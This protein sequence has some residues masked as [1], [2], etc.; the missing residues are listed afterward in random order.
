MGGA[1]QL[2]MA[3]SPGADFGQT[4]LDTRLLLTGRCCFPKI[5]SQS[6]YSAAFFEFCPTGLPCS[7][8]GDG[9]TPFHCCSL[10]RPHASRQKQFSSRVFRSNAVPPLSPDSHSFTRL[11]LFLRPADFGTCIF[12]PPPPRQAWV[13]LH[14][15]RSLP[16]EQGTPASLRARVSR[17]TSGQNNIGGN[18][19]GTL[20][21]HDPAEGLPR[22]RR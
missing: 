10:A 8:R 22:S 19:N 5:G 2:A 4:V 6:E 20:R 7:I 13:P 14:K 18:D 1:L 11:V 12:R 17:V 3:S 15:T 16:W 21:K 9:A